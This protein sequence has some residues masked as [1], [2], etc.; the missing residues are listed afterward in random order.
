MG[1]PVFSEG[2][3]IV[4]AEGGAQYGSF[5][6]KLSFIEIPLFEGKSPDK[7]AIRMV[8]YAGGVSGP[9]TQ[10]LLADCYFA[11]M[12][13]SGSHNL[14]QIAPSLAIILN[15]KARKL[16]VWAS[17]R[18]DKLQ[19]VVMDLPVE[20]SINVF[21]SNV[22][23]CINQIKPQNSMGFFLTKFFCKIYNIL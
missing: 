8:F 7:L 5:N 16:V 19:S 17:S 10:V 6:G 13:G 9:D 18:D 20:V 22:F 14:D 2:T 11:T 4:Q 21:P 15:K 12:I 3:K 1:V 23:L